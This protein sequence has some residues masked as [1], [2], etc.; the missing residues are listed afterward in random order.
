[1]S[2]ASLFIQLYL[3]KDVSVLVAQLLHPHGFEVLTTRDAHVENLSDSA[4][5]HN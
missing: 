5:F 1:M 2:D 3:D 4:H